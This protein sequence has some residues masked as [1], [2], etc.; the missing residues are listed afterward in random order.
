MVAG[1]RHNRR[2][3]QRLALRRKALQ[4]YVLTAAA[5][6]RALEP[7]QSLVVSFTASAAESTLHAD[8][9]FRRSTM[10]EP[11]RV[12]LLPPRLSMLDMRSRSADVP[13]EAQAPLPALL[14]PISA[15]LISPAN[16]PPSVKRTGLPLLFL[17]DR[18]LLPQARLD[19]R[20]SMDSAASAVGPPQPVRNPQSNARE[21][22]FRP[23]AH[24]HS[25]WYFSPNP[26]DEPF[27][28]LDPGDQPRHR[29]LLRH[30]GTV[31][32]RSSRR[33]PC[34]FRPSRGAQ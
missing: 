6:S 15:R 7:C 17:A 30:A 22:C 33:Q 13:T 10:I 3:W 28:W 27:R 19:E 34:A 11:H 9:L 26:V 1:I 25:E 32:P 20:F 8:K 2:Y 29:S 31:E 14:S 23:I 24:R 18:A 12:T 4:A 16:W 21:P 5:V